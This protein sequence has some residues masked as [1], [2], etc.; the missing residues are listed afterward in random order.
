MGYAGCMGVKGIEQARCEGCG[1]GRSADLPRPIY[2]Q[3]V[4]EMSGVLR[5][6]AASHRL[7]ADLTLDIRA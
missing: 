7:G 4:P 6:D 3:N 1:Q 2:R 5:A